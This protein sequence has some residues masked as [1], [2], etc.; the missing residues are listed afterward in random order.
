MHIYI[1]NIQLLCDLTL[2]SESELQ[3]DL[4]VHLSLTPLPSSVTNTQHYGAHFFSL[5]WSFRI[6]QHSFLGPT[7]SA[8]RMTITDMTSFLRQK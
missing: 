3:Q 6:F 2:N 7:C 4:G 5:D 1:Y 8:R